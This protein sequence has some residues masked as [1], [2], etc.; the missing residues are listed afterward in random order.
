LEFDWDRNNISHLQRHNI[1]PQEAEEVFYDSDRCLHNAYDGRRKIVG[2]T[3]NGRILAIV[4]DK[5]GKKFRPF[6]GWEA[7]ET[8]RKSYNK[9]R[10]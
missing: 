6:T 8:E 3:E 5:N 4:Y 10:R 1:T 9:R 2:M 7:T